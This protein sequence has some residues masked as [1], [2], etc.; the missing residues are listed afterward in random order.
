MCGFVYEWTNKINGKKYI[1]SHIGNLDDKYI[2]SGTIFSRA[3]AKYGLENFER[4]ILEIVTDISCLRERE[5]FYIDK[6]DAARNKRYYNVKPKVGGGF[7]YVNSNPELVEKNTERCKWM[8]HLSPK[9][10]GKHHTAQAWDKTRTGWKKWA[11]ENLKKPVLQYDLN[12]NF[13]CE[14]ESITAA[15]RSVNG[16]PSNIKYTIEGTFTK[17]YGY[18]WKYKEH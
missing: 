2:G 10:T 16:S 1:G 7:E 12:M 18:K 5:Q 15:A 3:L 9:F 13:I 14:H 11:N 8:T 17:A 4:Q 6:V